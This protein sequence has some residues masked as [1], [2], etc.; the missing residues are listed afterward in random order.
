MS[1]PYVF[2]L[3]AAAAQA[4]LLP[5]RLG[6]DSHAAPRHRRAPPPRAP[7]LTNEEILEFGAAQVWVL[8]G[9]LATDDEYLISQN[10]EGEQ[11]TLTWEVEADA[12]RYAEMLCAVP[13]RLES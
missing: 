7:L 8:V 12:L 11:W 9:N 3:L 13:A 6:L 2:A 5:S 4:A 1:V 10:R